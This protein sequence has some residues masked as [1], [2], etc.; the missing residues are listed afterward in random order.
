MG[1]CFF[2]LDNRADSE[3]EKALKFL[4]F[5]FLFVYTLIRFVSLTPSGTT[6]PT[7]HHSS[8]HTSGHTPWGFASRSAGVTSSVP[9]IAASVTSPGSIASITTSVASVVT[10]I[11]ASPLASGST[12]LAMASGTTMIASTAHHIHLTGVHATGKLRFR[13]HFFHFHFMTI[14]VYCAFFQK[15]FG[16]VFSFVRDKAEVFA[17]TLHLVE[18]LF[19]VGDGSES[20]HVIF[21]VII[22]E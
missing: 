1:L 16:Y 18:G 6:T 3:Q 8:T 10:S 9:S 11:S 20:C 17:F 5:L 4:F 13:S 7:T 2:E 19:N 15:F 22:T 14:N 12:P 21:D